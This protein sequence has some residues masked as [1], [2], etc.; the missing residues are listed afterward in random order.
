MSDKLIKIIQ[1]CEKL[2]NQGLFMQVMPLLKDVTMNDI[3]GGRNVLPN[4]KTFPN[5]ENWYYIKVRTSQISDSCCFGFKKKNTDFPL[6]D[7]KGMH[8]FMKIING[9]IKVTSYTFPNQETM[10]KYGLVADDDDI[11]V[12]YEGETILS[13][14]DDTKDT[15]VYLGPRVGNVHTIKSLEDNSLFFDFL[16]PGYINCDSQYFKLKNKE[17]SVKKGD[18]IYLTKI[19]RPG[20]FVMSGFTL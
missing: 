7:H 6:H 10:K 5:L 14:N 11:P 4:S 15:V 8:G 13:C 12:I 20:D 17:K 9:T 2:C 16:V 3:F 19:P 1:E 18:I